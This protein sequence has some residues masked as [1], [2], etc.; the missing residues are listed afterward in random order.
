M[1]TKYYLISL[2]SIL[3]ISFWYNSLAY[4]DRQKKISF[5]LR[6]LIVT[7]TLA[8]ICGFIGL[9]TGVNPISRVTNTVGRNSGFAGMPM[10]FAQN[11]VF[12]VTLNLGLIIHHKSFKKVFSVTW[13][14][15]FFLINLFALYT[16][17][18]RGP[19][20]AF[21]ASIPFYF[22]R[23]TKIFISIIIVSLAVGAGAYFVARDKLS[24]PGSDI[25][26][27]SQWKAAIA[28]FKERPVLGLGFMNFESMSLGLKSKY[29]IEA[30]YM[31]GHAHSN[32]FELLASTG[33]LGFIAFMLWQI[34][35]FK[36]MYGR[37]DLLGDMVMPLIVVFVVA[38]LTQATFTLGANLFLIMSLYAYSQVNLKKR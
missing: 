12:F 14:V 32:Y 24:R 9:K 36:E 5:C 38:G 37:K 33:L 16:T 19:L 2:L 15:A 27:I 4:E 10:N 22:I 25:E 6:A 11:L 30:A 1:K 34:F 17:Y 7:A 28:G 3:P 23:K 18:T 20:L 29:H 21:L 31:G 26:R 8:G 13:L 35:W